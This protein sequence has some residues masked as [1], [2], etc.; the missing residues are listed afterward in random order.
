MSDA[1]RVAQNDRGD[2]I[3]VRDIANSSRRLLPKLKSRTDQVLDV[4]LWLSVI[5]ITVICKELLADSIKGN[6]NTSILVVVVASCFVLY[7]A[8]RRIREN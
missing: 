3:D 8:I 5:I 1:Q 4:L 6:S 7:V 2:I